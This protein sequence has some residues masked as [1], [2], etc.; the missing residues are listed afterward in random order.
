MAVLTTLLL[1]RRAGNGRSVCQGILLLSRR[2]STFFARA[3]IGWVGADV[4]V[5]ENVGVAIFEG[6]SEGMSETS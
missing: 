1:H 2:R 4:L 6:R 3:C 5:R